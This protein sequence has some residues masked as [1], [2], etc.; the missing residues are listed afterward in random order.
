MTAAQTPTQIEPGRSAAGTATG[1]TL[2]R[3]KVVWQTRSD[4]DVTAV[5]LAVT[6]LGDT[7]NSPYLIALCDAWR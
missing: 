2:L 5:G 4:S 3:D 6:N 1:A 7:D